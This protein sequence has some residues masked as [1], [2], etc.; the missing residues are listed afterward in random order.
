MPKIRA[1]LA[2]AGV[3]CLVLVASACGGGGG[4]GGGGPKSVTVTAP[5][6]GGTPSV[7]IEAHDIYLRPNQIKAP[8]GKLRIRYVEDGAQ[9]HTLV[10]QGVKGFELKVSPGGKSD[11][12]TVTLQPG[13]YTYYCTIPGHRAQGMQGTLTVS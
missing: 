4:G 9:Q 11:T 3:G 5:S 6:G 2:T 13:E 8:A 10:I 1:V 12:G 7:T